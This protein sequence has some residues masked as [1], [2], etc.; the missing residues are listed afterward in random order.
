MRACASLAAS[1]AQGPAADWLAKWASQ[2]LLPS[3]TPGM[4]EEGFAP[5]PPGRKGQLGPG[6]W[7]PP[8]VHPAGGDLVP[9]VPCRG[10]QGQGGRGGTRRGDGLGHIWLSLGRV[11]E[12]ARASSLCH[13]L[14]SSHQDEQQ[15]LRLSPALRRGGQVMDAPRCNDTGFG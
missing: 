11:S 2:G 6:S 8:Q 10:R 7:P 14:I 5:L 3:S 13:V 9:A 4:R 12:P 1:D 15:E